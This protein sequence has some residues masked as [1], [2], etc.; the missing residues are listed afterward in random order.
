MKIAVRIVSNAMYGVT[1]FVVVVGTFIGMLYPPTGT[2]DTVIRA[3]S[4]CAVLP[5]SSVTLRYM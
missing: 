2:A 4:D 5:L 1:G 3:V